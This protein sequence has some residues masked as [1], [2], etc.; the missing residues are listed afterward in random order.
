MTHI[1]PEHALLQEGA[2][3]AAAFLRA[4]GNESR[5]LVLCLLG[6]HGELSVG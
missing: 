5:L 3:Q 4:L 2:Q 6:K 1:N